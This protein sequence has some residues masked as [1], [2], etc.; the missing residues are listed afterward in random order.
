MDDEEL[1]LW[2]HSKGITPTMLYNG[3][4]LLVLASMISLN[5]WLFRKLKGMRSGKDQADNTIDM[6]WTQNMHEIEVDF[7]LPRA[8]MRRSD[9]ECRIT[10]KSIRFA[11]R[12][13]DTP[14]L[15]GEF[16]KNVL[17][18]ECNWQ[19]WPVGPSPSHIKL[20]IIKEKEGLWKS[21]LLI[22]ATGKLQQTEKDDGKKK[23][24]S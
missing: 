9:V 4:L 13:D 15:D 3:L 11:F 19:F 12:G 20:S 23:K 17:S 18:E 21:L 10:S 2:L 5:V 22:D 14:M 16:M 24:K 1:I 6:D 7:P 8:D